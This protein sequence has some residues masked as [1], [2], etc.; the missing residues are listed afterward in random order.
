MHK[1]LK[2]AFERLKQPPVDSREENRKNYLK[3]LNKYDEI[4][5]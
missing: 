4:R 3:E 2:L 5:K 1:N